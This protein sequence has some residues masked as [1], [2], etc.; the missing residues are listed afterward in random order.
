[1]DLTAA[2]VAYMTREEVRDF[3]AD[4][5]QMVAERRERLAEGYRRVTEQ[6]RDI[7]RLLDLTELRLYRLRDMLNEETQ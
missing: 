1:M 2:Q 4:S 5:F 6:Q 3:F 7:T